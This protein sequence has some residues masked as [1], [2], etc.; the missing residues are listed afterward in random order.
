MP[1]GK[2][3]QVDWAVQGMDVVVRRIIR[4]GDG[5]VHE[6]KIVSKYRPWKA[7][8]LYGPGTQIPGQAA[9]PKP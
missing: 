9:A 6:E 7:I 8:Y 4:G 5:Q 3:K 1:A 2:I